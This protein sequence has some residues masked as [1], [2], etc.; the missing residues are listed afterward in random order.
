MISDTLPNGSVLMAPVNPMHR[1]DTL[2]YNPYLP[3]SQAWSFGG[4][5]VNGQCNMEE[6]SWVK[7]ADGSILA[8]DSESTSSERYIPSLNN[9]HGG[10]QA[11]GATKADVYDIYQYEEGPAFLLPNGNAIFIGSSPVTAIYIPSPLGGANVGTWVSGPSL[12]FNN[13]MGPATYQ[14]CS[15]TT[16][17]MPSTVSLGAP[18]APAAM[19]V[20]GKILCA[21][22][23]APSSQNQCKLSPTYFYEYDYAN[24]SPANPYGTFTQIHAPGG[25]YTYSGTTDG[26]LM[27]D[28][29]DGTVLY[30]GNGSPQYPGYQQLWIYTPDGSPL[31]V[32]K[33]AITSVAENED[34]SYLLTGTG[35]NGI[36]EGAAFGDD[37]QMNS[38]YPIVRLTDMTTGLVYYARTYNW[39]S[40]GIMTGSTPETTDFTLPPNL[41][42]D[43]YWLSVIANGN[44]SDPV[45]LCVQF[46]LPYITKLWWPLAHEYYYTVDWTGPGALQ[47]I[48]SLG[49]GDPWTT[50]SDVTSPYTNTFSNTQE[51]FRVAR[52]LYFGNS[53]IPPAGSAADS[54]S[55][56]VILGEYNSAG[57]SSNST[58]T[59]S[60][61]NVQDV[62]FY[63]QNYNF[64]LYALSLLNSGPGTNEQTFQVVAS[65]SFSG[66]QTNAGLQSLV[67]SNFTISSGDFL[68]FAGTGPYYAQSS[69]D[70]IYSDATY[71]N[72]TN[73]GSFQATPPGG[74]GAQFVLGLNPDTNATYEYVP[75]YFENQGRTYALGVDIL[76]P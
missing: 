32:G 51:F 62:K 22:S 7:L 49:G 11:E 61:G 60:S 36:S 48:P 64:T 68:A 29:P 20:N 9:G 47:S 18:D 4:S 55:P 5:L 76:P 53:L 71:E 54:I 2:I 10:W 42:L 6:A 46:Q 41:P 52:P 16:E 37:S 31:A 75:D 28:L 12:T 21:L 65:Q 40:T 67:V 17:N 3:S 13:V 43:C 57:P 24:T 59:L 23:Q 39:S 69:N 73:P 34:G 70:Q 72:S 8:I 14:N 44:A 25:G 1:G 50:I 66:S 45:T 58:V 15:G 35:L 19:M 27:L 33:P 30:V 56:L 74:V 26:S 63:G 38:D